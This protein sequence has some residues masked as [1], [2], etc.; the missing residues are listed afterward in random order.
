MKKR[1]EIRE[2]SKANGNQCQSETEPGVLLWPRDRYISHIC[3][4][5]LSL[6]VPR[7]LKAKERISLLNSNKIES[8]RVYV[9]S[10]QFITRRRRRKRN[11]LRTQV[12]NAQLQF[13]RHHSLRVSYLGHLLVDNFVATI[14][15][16]TI[17]LYQYLLRSIITFEMI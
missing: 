14:L 17:L 15:M 4:I 3:M 7:T 16:Y 10:V 12:S 9:E 6:I 5:H 2:G 13:S 11:D 8:R 1:H